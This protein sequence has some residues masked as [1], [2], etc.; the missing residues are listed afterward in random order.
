MLNQMKRYITP[1][2]RMPTPGGRDPKSLDVDWGQRARTGR[3]QR[4][5]FV[6]GFITLESRP[7]P[8]RASVDCSDF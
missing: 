5:I 1:A 8:R 3:I 6:L 4:I 7:I 2:W